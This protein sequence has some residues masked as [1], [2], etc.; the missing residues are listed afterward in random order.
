MDMNLRNVIRYGCC[1]GHKWDI[2]MHL[3]IGDFCQVVMV[4]FF[5]THP[6]SIVM[7]YTMLPFNL[8]KI[9]N[10]LVVSKS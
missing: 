4:F 10:N 7:S 8:N 3:C 6:Q 9:S 2:Q 1:W 5:L